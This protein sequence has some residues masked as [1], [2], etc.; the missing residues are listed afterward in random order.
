ML[1]E[2]TLSAVPQVGRLH[3]IL[4][5]QPADALGRGVRGPVVV[6]HEHALP[7]PA[8]HQRRA[9]ARGPATDDHG[10]VVR[11]GVREAS[12]GRSRAVMLS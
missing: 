10:G 4:P 8:Q 1:P 2:L 5:E 12:R 7:C 9:Q 6:H 11:R 3:P